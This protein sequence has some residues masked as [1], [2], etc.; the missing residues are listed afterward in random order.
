[1]SQQEE[2][3]WDLTKVVAISPAEESKLNQFLRKLNKNI[4]GDSELQDLLG[5]PVTQWMKEID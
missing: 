5:G 4:E 2:A 1:M 3:P